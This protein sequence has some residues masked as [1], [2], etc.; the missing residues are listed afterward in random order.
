M[1]D[2]QKLYQKELGFSS[3]D[4][5]SVVEALVHA[6]QTALGIVSLRASNDPEIVNELRVALFKYMV[7]SAD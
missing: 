2:K 6:T 3:E 4:L 5:Q 1:I 7:D